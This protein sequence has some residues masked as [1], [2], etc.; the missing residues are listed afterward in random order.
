MPLLP[1]NLTTLLGVSMAAAGL[2]GLSGCASGPLPYKE[3]A[4]AQFAVNEAEGAG[5]SRY[6]PVNLR[7]ARKKLEAAERA[8]EK[9]NYEKASRL[10]EQAIVDA[11]L[12]EAKARTAIQRRNVKALRQSIEAL[13]NELAK[14]I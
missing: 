1:K 8:M 3:I 14:H 6:A 5:A 10:A 7:N 4:T 11:Q 12:A 9:G 13:R 2:L